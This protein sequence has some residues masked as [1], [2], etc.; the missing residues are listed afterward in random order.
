MLA[1]VAK[2]EQ[3]DMLLKMAETWDALARSREEQVARLERIQKITA[4]VTSED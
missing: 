4:P 1:T 3:R 2:P